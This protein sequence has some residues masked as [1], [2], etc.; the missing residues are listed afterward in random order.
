ML[1]AA[2]EVSRRAEGGAVAAE[3]LSGGRMVRS[4]PNGESREDSVDKVDQL[5]VLSFNTYLMQAPFVGHLGIANKPQLKNRADRIARWLETLPAEAVPDVMVFQEIFSHAATEIFRRVCSEDYRR[6]SAPPRASRVSNFTQSRASMAPLGDGA[7]PVESGMDTIFPCNVKDSKFGYATV[8]LNKEKK[9]SML[10]GGV[11]ILSKKGVKLSEYQEHQFAD[12]T[13]ADKYSRKGFMIVRVDREEE[14]EKFSEPTYVVGTHTQAWADNLAVDM[15]REQFWQIRRATQG[16]PGRAGQPP[17]IAF[18]GDFNVETL[19]VRRKLSPVKQYLDALVVARTD[20]SATTKRGQSVA[21]P[22]GSIA[23]VVERARGAD[24]PA[25][26]RAR[27]EGKDTELRVS[28]AELDK[29]QVMS[30][31]M[32]D[33]RVGDTAIER[34]LGKSVGTV[35][36]VD[37]AGTPTLRVEAAGGH[38]DRAVAVKDCLVLVPGD[39][40]SLLWDEQDTLKQALQ[41]GERGFEPAGF[42]LPLPGRLEASA[43]SG[44]NAFL[45]YD[46]DAGSISQYDWVLA[47]A[48]GDEPWDMRWQN[49]PVKGESCFDVE[50]LYP[51]RS[52]PSPL[53]RVPKTDDLSDH[54]A[55]FAQVCFGGACPALAGTLAESS[56][57]HG[58]SQM[59]TRCCDDADGES[60]SGV[61]GGYQGRDFGAVAAEAASTA[62][63]AAR[64]MYSHSN[65]FSYEPACLSSPDD[66]TGEA[67]ACSGEDAI[68]AD[69]D[70]RAACEQAGCFFSTGVP[71]FPGCADFLNMPMKVGELVVEPTAKAAGLGFCLGKTGQCSGSKPFCP[72]AVKPPGKELGSPFLAATPEQC[73]A[74][75]ADDGLDI[76]ARGLAPTMTSQLDD[77]HAEFFTMPS[78]W[79]LRCN[80]DCEA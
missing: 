40:R 64:R 17:R 49:L 37:A 5:T 48:A 14:A 13:H 47:R 56:L 41:A 51:A 44:R 20:V 16:L 6:V 25:R 11:V 2:I 55:V 63:A 68:L 52:G 4:G 75:L 35:V 34:G 78:R 46:E 76:A 69:E 12:A 39:G 19:A 71:V 21:L 10:C 18:A 43:F 53:R 23:K 31:A 28:L 38:A 59:N 57:H 32:T 61:V 62:P 60:F 54:F 65:G 30:T 1:A 80:G 29:L 74:I 77:P 15:R 7:A 22:A 27:H 72:L 36:S 79:R 33:C 70:P 45:T 8:A 73:L 42:Y 24:V 67:A 3:V 58:G 9:Q 26:V 50:E 66:G